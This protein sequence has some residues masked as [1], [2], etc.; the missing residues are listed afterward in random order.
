MN[1]VTTVKKCVKE[2]RKVAMKL[3]REE[4]VYPSGTYINIDVEVEEGFW[5]RR[6]VTKT[7]RC[8]RKYKFFEVVAQVQAFANLLGAERVVN[9]AEYTTAHDRIGDDGNT[10]FVVW[11]WDNDATEVQQPV[12]N[13]EQ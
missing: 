5:R 10:H 13:A 6:K 7:E 2:G 8:W 4:F 11:Y 9:I 12:Q 3:K 1:D